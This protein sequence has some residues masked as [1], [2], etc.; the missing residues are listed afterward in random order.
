MAA[1]EG[2]TNAFHTNYTLRCLT[3][4]RSGEYEMGIEGEKQSGFYG[5]RQ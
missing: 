4:G 2:I 3:G 1:A 5:G